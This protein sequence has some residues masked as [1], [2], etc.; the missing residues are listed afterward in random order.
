MQDHIPHD[1]F[2]AR[3]EIAKA[4][5]H[6]A[7][8][9]MIEILNREGKKCVCEFTEIMELSQSSVSKHLKIL[10]SAGIISSE[11]RGVRTYYSLRT[12]CVVNFFSCMDE[13]LREDLSRRDL[14]SYL[15][16]QKE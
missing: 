2:E 10:K 16:T 11:K 8:L 7:R 4:L 3:A 6:P 15:D 1:L 5:G 12:P 9:E 14:S 13:V